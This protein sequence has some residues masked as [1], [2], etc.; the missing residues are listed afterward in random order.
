[1]L[2]YVLRRLLIAVPILFGITLVVFLML[3][4]AGGDPAEL[5]LGLHADPASIAKLRHQLGLDRPLS[6][7]YLDFLRGALHGD[8]G[9][10][11]RSNTL[12]THEVLSRF[13]ATIEL[14]VAAMLI[15]LLIGISM[16]TLAATRRHSIFDY[17]STLVALAGVA[18]PTFWLG[19]MLIIVF[20]LW[21]RWLPIAGRIDPRLGLDPSV[22]FVLVHALVHGEW[23]I[24]GD[25]LKHLILPAI[26]LA[27]WPAAIIA[28]MTRASLIETLGQDY[29]RTARAKGLRENLIVARHAYRNALIPILTVVG[30]E[31]GSLLG[32]AVVTETVFAWPGVGGLTI[33]AI[34]NRDYQ[35]VQGIVILL[36]VVFVLLNLG[37]DLV[38][39]WLD[40]RIR[41]A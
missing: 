18:I 9:R 33:N 22:H 27:G 6:V 7:Q 31:F 24:F 39:A 35:V 12:V 11:Y 28:R 30:L 26:T 20:G 15:A 5:I 36:G 3:H 34:N 41:Y 13:P 25:A 40:P 21:L 38:Y 37:V 17:S 14:A 23:Q 8:L 1:M 29:I 4:G 10:S 16:G 2:A 19:L 32:G